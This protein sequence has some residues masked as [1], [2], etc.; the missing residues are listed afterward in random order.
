MCAQAPSS[1]QGDSFMSQLS[2][3]PR[4]KKQLSESFLSHVNAYALAAGAAGVSIM[5]LAQPS[6]AEIVFT[7]AN[8]SIPHNKY[9]SLD[10]N[11]D[12][13]P[14]FRFFLY[15]FAY[16]SFR[17]SLNVKGGGVMGQAGGFAA[18]LAA[19]ASVGP[20][21]QFFP[22]TL[23]MAESHGVAIYSSI[24]SR[25]ETGPWAN[26]QN[27]YLGVRFMISGT[28]HYGWIRLTVGSTRHPL[29]G[30]ITGYAYETVAG[31]PIQAGQTSG[32]ASLPA[33]S[34]PMAHASLGMLAMGWTGLELWRREEALPSAQ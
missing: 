21:Q 19:G 32:A 25:T 2:T 26:V 13:T 17:A 29:T 10:L 9:I 28:V 30:T 18:P 27:R 24:Y 16:H 6:E 14:D 12:G 23:R 15:T 31:K 20:G 8:G 5:A 22:G 33:E 11:H 3:G 7:P 34:A 1:Y 4:S